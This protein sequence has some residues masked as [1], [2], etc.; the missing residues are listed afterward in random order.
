MP[1]IDFHDIE[2]ANARFNEKYGVN[3]N[4]ATFEVRTQ[5]LKELGGTVDLNANY[6]GEFKR[7][8]KMAVENLVERKIDKSFNP[9]TMLNEFENDIMAPYRQWCKESKHDA[10]AVRGGWS[11]EDAAFEMFSAVS[12]MPVTAPDMAEE[13]YLKG[14]L[15]LRKMRESME[16]VKKSEVKTLDQLK[17]LSNYA[18]A[19]QSV[20]KN[21]TLAWK[22]RHPF[23][24][25]AEQRDMDAMRKFVDKQFEKQPPADCTDIAAFKKEQRQNRLSAMKDVNCSP[26][27]A[28]KETLK[29]MCSDA[30]DREKARQAEARENI[31]VDKIDV[32]ANAKIEE[33]KSETLIKTNDLA[34]Q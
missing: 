19:L 22:I 12:D 2:A 3:F 5:T 33:K 34:K 10:P 4:I 18:L 23:R 8:F 32:N 28:L 27:P 15:P 13:R 1:K 11:E 9:E 25:R 20:T 30:R 21:R 24:N 26:V 17:T 14:E 7:I 6:K 29:Q 16:Q 31:R